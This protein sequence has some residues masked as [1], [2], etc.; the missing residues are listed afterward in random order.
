MLFLVRAEVE[1][2]P[3]GAIAELLERVVGE[4]E[5]VNAFAASGQIKACGK[6]AGR[7]GAVAIFDVAD[8]AALEDIVRRLPLAPFFTRL[9]IERLVPAADALRRA[10]MRRE[11]FL[12]KAGPAAG[13]AK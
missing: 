12:D 2:P 5:L 10:R 7:S 4:W 9:E 13:A 6:L 11:I 3:L 1:E 8:R